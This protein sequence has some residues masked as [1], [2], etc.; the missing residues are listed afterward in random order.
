MLLSCHYCQAAIILLS[1]LFYIYIFCCVLALADAKVCMPLLSSF[2]C[3]PF[4]TMLT[5]AN[6]YEAKQSMAPASCDATQ[7][8]HD[9]CIDSEHIMYS[10][11]T[12]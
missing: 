8:K 2:S 10:F 6:R 4:A 9:V 7:C 12:D 11:L 1:L 3:T 5:A